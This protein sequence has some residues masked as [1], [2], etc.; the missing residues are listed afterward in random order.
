MVTL[1]MVTYLDRACIGA[2]KQHIA[3]GLQPRR[4]ADG[5]GLHLVHPRLRHLRDPHG[6]LGRPPRRRLRAHAHRE[7]VVG[8]HAAHRRRVQLRLAAC[9]PLPVRRRRSRRIPVRGARALALG[10]AARTRYRERHLLLRR[11][12]I[13]GA[14]HLHRER[15]AALHELAHHPARVRLRGIRVGHRL[16][17]LVPR[18][19][20]RPPGRQR[21]RTRADH[22]RPHAGRSRIRPASRT[23]AAC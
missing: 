13:G 17:A 6:A 19:A 12:R 9:H 14:D 2:M 23:G 20:H 8:V 11:L 15:A 1:A 16:E 21:R 18:R 7:L 5:L 4:R 22:R 10:A 3:G